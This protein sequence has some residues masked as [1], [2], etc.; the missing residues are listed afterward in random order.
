[1]PPLT[2]IDAGNRLSEAVIYNGILYTC[3]VVPDT[4]MGKSV[5]EQT[6][7]VLAQIDAL[8]ARAG[9]DKTRILKA[10]I[11]LASMQFYDEMN[12]VWDAWVVP[13]QPPARATVEARLAHPEWALEIMI[14]AA[15][16]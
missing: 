9:S 15:L 12:Q 13:G 1:M 6:L 16:G 2:R 14:E 11:W 5:R 7:D 4:A 3:G 8:L 10:T